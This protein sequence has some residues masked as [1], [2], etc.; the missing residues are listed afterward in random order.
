[1]GAILLAIIVTVLPEGL[2]LDDTVKLDRDVEFIGLQV[3]AEGAIGRTAPLDLYYKIDKP[4]GKDWWIFTHIELQGKDFRRITHDRPPPPATNGIVHHHIDIPI[5]PD[6]RAARFE[7]FTG[8]WNK[9]TDERLQVLDP[10]SMDDRIHAGRISLV[11]EKTLDDIRT[12]SRSNMRIQKVRHAVRPWV[13]WILA[14]LAACALLVVLI[15]LRGR[16]ALYLDRMLVLGR[17]P[18][19]YGPIAALFVPLLLS[20]LAALDFVKDDA[21]ISFRYTHNLVSGQGLVFNPGERLEGYTNL[22][23]SIVM[24]PFEAAGADLFQVCEI[25]GTALCF[26][27]LVFL[28]LLAADFSGGRKNL[29]HLWVGVWLAASSSMALWS[30]SGME[31]P[32]AMFLPVAS[33]LLLWRGQKQEK[34]GWVLA[35]GIL[36]ALACMTR[37]ENHLAAII[38]G[39]TLAGETVLRRPGHGARL[40]WITA[41][42]GFVIPFHLFRYLYFGSLLPNT[43][44]VKT[45][46]SLL[47]V[48]KGLDKLRDMFSFNLTGMLLVLSPLAFIDRRRLK[49]KLVLLAIAVGFML[50][51]VK[52]GVDEMRWHRLFLPALPFLALLAALGLTNLC[53]AAA[54]MLRSKRMRLLPYAAGWIVVMAAASWNFAFTCGQMGGLNGRGELSGTYHPDIGKF[55]TRHERPGA[56]VAFQDMG[57]TPYHAPDINFFDFIGLVEGK[58]ARARHSY[59]LNAYTATENYRNQDTFDAEMRKYFFERNPEWT[60]LTIY[61]PGHMMDRVAGLFLSDPGPESMLGLQHNNSYQ[62]QITKDPK[63]NENYVHVRTWQ[64]SSTYYLALYR[65]RNL[66]EQVPGEVVLASIPDGIGGVKVKFERGLEIIGS[67]M[68]EEATERHEAFIT[69]WWRVSGPMEPDV[70]F[71][72]H[73]GNEEDYQTNLDHPPGDWMFPADRWRPGDIIED[74]VLFQL[75]VSMKPGTYRV[76]IG[77]YRRSTGERFAILDGPDDGTG[78]VPLGTLEVKHMLPFVHHLIPPTDV[79]DQRKYPDKIIDPGR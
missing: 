11:H 36:M 26:A 77:V 46:A 23:W 21:Y 71:F 73:V 64:R 13:G 24:A 12:L 27:L 28:T 54:G 51:I 65:R 9:T 47:L 68:E 58:V 22:L 79:E 62:F 30:T 4:L 40:L 29:S 67:E 61:A 31:Q 76:Y 56:L 3:P 19:F 42:L 70:L 78:R 57:S 2:S 72:L 6:C 45:G 43:Y 63:F 55:L 32:L 39:L 60:I 75:P 59:G 53:D 16:Y 50:Y 35:S 25:L 52:V 74:R 49:E 8:V 10:P 37:P 33:L 38:V 14:V 34:T 7:I 44:Y 17:G 5:P 18:R 41:V 48:L 1:M 66:W 20:I 15:R 69:T